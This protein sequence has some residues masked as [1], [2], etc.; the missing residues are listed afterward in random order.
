MLGQVPD[1]V[2]GDLV[3]VTHQ[4]VAQVRAALG[5][6]AY[7]GGSGWAFLEESNEP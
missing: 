4:R 5:I 7:R 6:G 3:G 2:V 1:R